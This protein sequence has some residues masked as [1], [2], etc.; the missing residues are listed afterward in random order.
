MKTNTRIIPP[1]ESTRD[2]EADIILH[3]S[4]IRRT[5]QKHMLDKSEES[6]LSENEIKGRDSIKDSV[7][8]KE[9]V[10]SF[11]DK[12]SRVV[13]STPELYQEAAEVHLKKDE[14]VDW[15]RLKTT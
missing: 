15:C 8:G 12:D 3:S 13:V 7:K 1:T 5:I 14:K 10:L 6:L 11:T 4:E 9:I 2:S